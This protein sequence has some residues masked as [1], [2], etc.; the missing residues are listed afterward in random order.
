MTTATAEEKTAAFWTIGGTL[1]G[2]N[3]S[4]LLLALIL[5]IVFKREMVKGFAVHM[6]VACLVITGASLLIAHFELEW[7]NSLDTAEVPNPMPNPI[8]YAVRYIAG[9]IDWIVDKNLV[10]IVMGTMT[11]EETTA[12]GV[13]LALLAFGPLYWLQSIIMT[14]GMWETQLGEVLVDSNG[15]TRSGLPSYLATYEGLFAQINREVTLGTADYALDSEAMATWNG[16]L[17]WFRVGFYTLDFLMW[18]VGNG[19]MYSLGKDKAP[20]E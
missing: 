1:A 14:M 16:E 7:I 10:A 5:E 4:P 9:C 6:T 2:L 18:L 20:K 19:M 3:L 17:L 8:E 13:S 11:E 12:F 15:D